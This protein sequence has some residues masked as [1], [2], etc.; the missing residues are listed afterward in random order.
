[1]QA[2][3]AVLHHVAKAVDLVVSVPRLEDHL[4]HSTCLFV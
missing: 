1:M 2:L 4:V 3:S